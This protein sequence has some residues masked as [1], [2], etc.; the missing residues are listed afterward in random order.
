M[1]G[2][3]PGEANLAHLG[4]L[5]PNE[6]PEFQPHVLKELRQTLETGESEI[7]LANH[8]ISYHSRIQPIAAINRC[9]CGGR[10]PDLSCKTGRLCVADYKARISEPLLHRVDL[11]IEALEVSAADLVLPTA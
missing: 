9:K 5:L 1:S 3:R 10:S 8:R 6:L 11:Q 7:D 4:P 2:T